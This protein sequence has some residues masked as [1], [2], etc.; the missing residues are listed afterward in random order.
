MR[1][2]PYPVVKVLPATRS[3]D[4]YPHGTIHTDGTVV[5]SLFGTHAGMSTVLVNVGAG[6]VTLRVASERI[7]VLP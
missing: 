5:G 2:H 3:D 7:E 1:D 4:P 6:S